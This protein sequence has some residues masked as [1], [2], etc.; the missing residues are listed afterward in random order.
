[1][2]GKRDLAAGIAARCDVTLDQL[3]QPVDLAFA[4]AERLEIGLR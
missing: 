4:E 1:V 3:D 2:A